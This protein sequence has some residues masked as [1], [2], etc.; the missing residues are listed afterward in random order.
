MALKATH[1]RRYPEINIG[2][3]VSIYMKRKA[4]QK[5]HV[6]LWSD[7]SYEVEDITT[8]HGMSFYKTSARDRPCLRHELLKHNLKQ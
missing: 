4:N 8:A 2:D 3:G 5:A 7:I 6:P 1:N